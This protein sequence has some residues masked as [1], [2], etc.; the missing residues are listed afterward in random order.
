[1]TTNNY[2]Y[3]RLLLSQEESKYLSAL[4]AGAPTMQLLYINARIEELRKQLESLPGD[5]KKAGK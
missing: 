1:M 3:L 5:P 2:D 4:K